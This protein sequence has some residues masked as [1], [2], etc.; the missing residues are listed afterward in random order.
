MNRKLVA[1]AVV[2]G[3]L[4]AVPRALAQKVDP[5]V[6]PPN[7][8]RS[9]TGNTYEQ[10]SAKWWQYVF[11][12]PAEVNPL[13]D[14]T[15]AQ[16]AVEQTG[17]D[18]RA[19]FFLVGAINVSG[20]ATRNDCTVPAGKPLF[21]PILNVETD[22]EGLTTQLAQGQLRSSFCRRHG[23]TGTTCDEMII[24]TV[25]ELHASIDG[26]AVPNL[27]F[28]RTKSAVFTYTF[29][30][31]DNVLRLTCTGTTSPTC[32]DSSGGSV[33][34]AGL[35]CTPGSRSFPSTC[36]VDEAVGDGFYL[37]LRPLSTGSHSV[38]F[39]G[40]FGPPLNFPL[41]V[42]YNLTVE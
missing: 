3:T 31:T 2:L 21:F 40:T 41:D 39:G 37:M 7:S 12:I 8:A 24:Q 17:P 4:V 5:R 18:T 32:T 9:E 25:T 19:V 1:V 29:P 35:T 10:W 20:T 36:T 33:P 14:A 28:F 15:G 13:F 22:N 26:V 34:F 23:L 42:T 38:N 27:T 6:V 30:A 11:S 16:C